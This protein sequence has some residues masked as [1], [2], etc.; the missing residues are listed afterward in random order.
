MFEQLENRLL[1]SAA[2]LTQLQSAPALASPAAITT[3]PARA[4]DGSEN[5]PMFGQNL[6]MI[7]SFSI[8]PLLGMLGFNFTQAGP[9]SDEEAN[10]LKLQQI[11]QKILKGE[12]V[13]AMEKSTYAES[14]NQQVDMQQK[15]QQM[16]AQMLRKR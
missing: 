14:L 13:S 4:D 12:E 16:Q 11:E 15:Q 2:I 6:Q 8:Y 10:A 7:L 1:L 5:W 3:A 9:V